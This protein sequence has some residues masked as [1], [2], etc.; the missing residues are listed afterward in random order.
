MWDRIGDKIASSAWL[1]GCAGYTAAALIISKLPFWL[2]AI[3][4]CVKLNELSKCMF[5][6]QCLSFYHQRQTSMV[7]AKCQF[8]KWSHETCWVDGNRALEKFPFTSFRPFP[9][10][11][12]RHLRPSRECCCGW[13]VVSQLPSMERRCSTNKPN[14]FLCSAI[15]ICAAFVIEKL[16][17]WKTSCCWGSKQP[18]EVWEASHGKVINLIFQLL[19]LAVFV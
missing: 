6:F 7:F 11:Q 19:Q 18:W 4:G 1:F 16:M 13:F 9:L 3:K 2:P 17:L 8:H 12:S 15:Q 14:N 5:R 10:F